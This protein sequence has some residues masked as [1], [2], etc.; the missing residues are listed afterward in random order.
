MAPNRKK[1]ILWGIGLTVALFLLLLLLA[2]LIPGMGGYLCPIYAITGLYCP[3]CGGTR[4][5][6]LLITGHFASAFR[7]NPPLFMLTPILLYLVGAQI[8]RLLAGR[9]IVPTLLPKT[10]MVIVF[11]SVLFLYG[12]L[13][14]IPGFEF[15]NGAI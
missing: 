12:I 7:M 9:E 1:E 5:F 11:V 10:W 15:L 6:L 4:M 8:L 13:R 14:N 3:A 2:G